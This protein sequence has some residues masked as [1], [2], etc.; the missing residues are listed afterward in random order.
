VTGS[1][2]RAPPGQA[3]WSRWPTP[4]RSCPS[5]AIPTNRHPRHHA[6][7]QQAHRKA[8]DAYATLKAAAAACIEAQLELLAEARAAHDDGV[9]VT[10]LDTSWLGVLAEE[11]VIEARTGPGQEEAQSAHIADQIG[12]VRAALRTAGYEPALR[13]EDVE[14]SGKGVPPVWTSPS[15][16]S[17]SPGIA[18]LAVR[19]LDGCA[20]RCGQNTARARPR[21]RPARRR[22]ADGQQ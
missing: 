1:S 16:G 13:I 6:Q 2:Q 5:S 17:P 10:E 9:T 7:L 8:H 20:C 19:L 11:A 4:C 21:S 12:K 3:S 18:D 14:Y 15:D 22:P